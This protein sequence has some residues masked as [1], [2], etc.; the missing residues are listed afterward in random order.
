MLKPQLE[1]ARI[2]FVRALPGH[3]KWPAPRTHLHEI[4]AA[5]IFSKKPDEAIMGQPFGPP[6]E[7]ADDLEDLLARGA[8]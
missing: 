7:V 1:S 8:D 6:P 5:R 2:R 4:A 3:R